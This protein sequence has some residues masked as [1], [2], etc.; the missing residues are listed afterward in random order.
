[1]VEISEQT[2]VMVSNLVNQKEQEI[3]Q[4]ERDLAEWDRLTKIAEAR[5]VVVEA[6]KASLETDIP[7]PTPVEV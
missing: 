5:K 3:A 2:K 6:E 7:K 4:I 1:M